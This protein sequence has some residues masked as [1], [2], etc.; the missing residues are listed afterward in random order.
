MTPNETNTVELLVDVVMGEVR[1][2]VELTR[3]QCCD[4]CRI[5][6]MDPL[7]FKFDLPGEVKSLL[8]WYGGPRRP[9]KR[10]NA[11][12]ITYLYRASEGMVRLNV[13]KRMA[14]GLL[15]MMDMSIRDEALKLA[16][17]WRQG[18]TKK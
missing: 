1:G 9:S 12:L 15:G 6:S 14:L 8:G 2:P 18:R 10:M 16:D 3:R 5:Y 13:G 7:Y 4:I 11:L 17:K